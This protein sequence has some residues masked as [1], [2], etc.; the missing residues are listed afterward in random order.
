MKKLKLIFGLLMVSAFVAVA[1]LSATSDD[2][3]AIR[4]D[5]III[6]RNG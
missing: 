1:V 4:K 5:R 2:N 3:T 6:P